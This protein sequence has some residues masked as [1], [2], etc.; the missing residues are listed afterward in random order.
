MP[1]QLGEHRVLPVSFGLRFE[2]TCDNSKVSNKIWLTP[3]YE[4]VS[5]S[6]LTYAAKDPSSAPEPPTPELFRIIGLLVETSI[7]LHDLMPARIIIP[8]R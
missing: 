6:A 5:N 8:L 2:Q 1:S 4:Q 3:K 7:H